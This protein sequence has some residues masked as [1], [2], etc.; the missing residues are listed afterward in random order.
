MMPRKKKDDVWLR[1]QRWTSGLA[2]TPLSEAKSAMEKSWLPQWLD[3]T[4]LEYDSLFCLINQ[5]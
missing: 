4:A 5:E 2:S 1:E 3:T